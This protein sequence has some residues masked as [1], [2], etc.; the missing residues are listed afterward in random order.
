MTTRTSETTVTFKRPF[1][2]SGFDAALP[3]GDYRVETEEERIEGLSY[4]AYRRTATILRLPPR[5]G[6]AHLT[7]AMT[8]DPDELRAALER[9]VERGGER[10]RT[11]AEGPP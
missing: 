2:L 8:I 11:G 5:S 1:L 9:D 7:R 4:A 6:P 3:A 10:A